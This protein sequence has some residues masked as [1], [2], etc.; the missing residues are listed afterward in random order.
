MLEIPVTQINK[1]NIKSTFVGKIN[2]FD[3][4][5]IAQLTARQ[6]S[7]GGKKR[8]FQRETD[9]KKVLKIASFIEKNIFN[10]YSLNTKIKDKQYIFSLFPTAMILS[11]NISDNILES[12]FITKDPIGNVIAIKIPDE[13]INTED[14]SVFIVDGQHRFEGVKTFYDN[15]PELRGMFD[16][17]F[18][19]TILLGYDIYEQSRIFANV[20]FEQKPVNKSLYYDIFGSLPYERNEITLAHYIVKQLNNDEDSPIYRMVKMLGTGEGVVSQ[21]FFVEKT[22]DLLNR[23]GAFREYF[24][25]YRS[26]GKKYKALPIIF[27]TYFGVLKDIFTDYWPLVDEQ[28]QFYSYKY[29][30]ILLKTTGLG[31]LLKLL[32]DL[33]N[34][35]EKKDKKENGLELKKYFNSIFTLFNEQENARLFSG[36]GI[37]AQG[38]GSG[39]QSKLYKELKNIINYKKNIIGKKYDNATIIDIQR[40][41]INSRDMNEVSMD[42]G[43]KTLLSN[44]EVN[45][46]RNQNKQK[47]T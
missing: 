21:A 44:D 4:E 8:F 27:K 18:P 35:L 9:G 32:N 46:I 37:Y 13:F 3:L 19:V 34:D 30:H 23:E 22:I 28:G 26:N 47:I 11:I 43:S 1:N 12:D 41:E 7:G 20:N 29:K 6:V 17:E 36:G 31:A 39:L 33:Q 14:K 42:N 16:I 10:D 38:A 15:H 5:K 40:K 45:I 2:F 24:L 25:D